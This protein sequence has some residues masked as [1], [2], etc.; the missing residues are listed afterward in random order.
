[1]QHLDKIC[2]LNF[3]VLLGDCTSFL[4]D[5]K[6]QWVQDLEHIT[7]AAEGWIPAGWQLKK[8]TIL[9]D[10]PVSTQ[11]AKEIT[12]YIDIF[13]SHCFNKIEGIQ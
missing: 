10:K 4:D 12:I 13:L 2:N 9:E 1:M 11:R 7:K 6:A 5:M 3:Q 8:D